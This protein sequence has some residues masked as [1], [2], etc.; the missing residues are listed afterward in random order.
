MDNYDKLMLTGMWG[1]LQFRWIQHDSPELALVFERML[2][3]GSPLPAGVVLAW[4]AVSAQGFGAAPFYLLGA[5]LLGVRRSWSVAEVGRW[6]L[7]SVAPAQPLG[8]ALAVP[9]A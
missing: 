8:A 7:G 9:G 3:S 2:L 5:L 1:T 4:A 6:L